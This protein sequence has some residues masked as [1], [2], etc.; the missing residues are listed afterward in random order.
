MP[1]LSAVI[2]AF[3]EEH[4]IGRCLASLAGV[5]DEVI[6]VDSG[7][8]DRTAEIARAHGARLVLHAWEGYSAQKN[9]ANSL[10]VSDFVL[11]IDADEALSEGLSAS[12]HALKAGRIS[13]DAFRLSRL[14]NY[15]GAWIR[16]S[17]WYPDARVRVWRRGMGHWE[18]LIHEV[19]QV[20]TD[21]IGHL[22]GDLL[23]YSYYT[24]HDHLRQLTHFTEI[25][26]RDYVQRGKKA[27]LFKIIFSPLFKFVQS[28]F[29]QLG[30]LD[31]YHGFV[32]CAVSAFA[33]FAKYVRTRQMQAQGTINE[34]TA[35]PPARESRK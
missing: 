16:H 20:Q 13:G 27:S 6:V 2:I 29:L 18:G 22:P 3:Q 30:F 28:Y 15:C 1:T 11:S 31:G 21:T 9:F 23:H 17:G 26:A 19:V 4:N 7:S 25:M 8:T 24:L 5:A 14:T 33:T 35:I 10:A 34:A 32:V 12:L